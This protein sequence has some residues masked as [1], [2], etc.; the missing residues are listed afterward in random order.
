M[1]FDGVYMDKFTLVVVAVAVVVVVVVVAVVV[2]RPTWTAS[3]SAKVYTRWHLC[4]T[5]IK[6]TQSAVSLSAC[7]KRLGND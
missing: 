7:L 4:G 2:G 3:S 5:P 6:G 1:W